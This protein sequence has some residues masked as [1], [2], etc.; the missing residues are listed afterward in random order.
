MTIYLAVTKGRDSFLDGDA[1]RDK[2][3]AIAHRQAGN[4]VYKRETVAEIAKI[5]VD[6]PKIRLERWYN[7]RNEAT[8]LKQLAEEII[9]EK[10]NIL[11]SQEGFWK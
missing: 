1:R 10:E 6:N 4:D 11:E 3:W 9:A 5:L 8:D 7:Q 2:K